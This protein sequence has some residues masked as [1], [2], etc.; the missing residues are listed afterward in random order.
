MI[1]NLADC[2]IVFLSFDEPNADDNFAALSEELPRAKRVHGVKGFDAA[3]RRA[4]ETAG[5]RHVVTIDADNV[6]LDHGFLNGKFG[7]SPRDLGSVF[8]FSARNVLNGLEYGNGG[9][10]IWPRD[11]LLSLRTHENAGRSEGAVDFCWTVP[12]YQVNRV[13]SEVIMTA[14]PAQAFRGGF[15]EGVK[16]NLADGILAYDALPGLPRAEA[17]P[18][19]VGA[20]NYERLRVWCSVGADVPNGDWAVFGARLGCVMTALEGFEHAKIA[21]YLWFSEFWETEILPTWGSAK[22]RSKRRKEL[23]A[24]L[25]EELDLNVTEFDRAGSAFFKSTYRGRRAFGPMRV[26]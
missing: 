20:S 21:D 10:K 26:V 13:L 9:V 17:L 23:G 25:N 4:G 11:T 2:D 3:H 19:H 24:L 8:S 16:F 15:R 12:Y 5:S 18:R 1:I 6:I 14:T 7:V 22:V